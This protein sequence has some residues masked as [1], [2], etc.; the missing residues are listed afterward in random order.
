M[1][2][3]CFCLSLAKSCWEV[4]VGMPVH[5]SLS[6]HTANLQPTR[7]SRKLPSPACAM[8]HAQARP[9]TWYHFQLI[10]ALTLGYVRTAG[11]ALVFLRKTAVVLKLLFPQLQSEQ[12]QPSGAVVQPHPSLLRETMVLIYSPT[13]ASSMGGWD[14][15]AKFASSHPTAK[16]MA[17][18][19]H[20][21]ALWTSQCEQRR[22]PLS[23]A[24]HP[25]CSFKLIESCQCAGLLQNWRPSCFQA[26]SGDQRMKEALK[27]FRNFPGAKSTS[28]PF[29]GT[30]HPAA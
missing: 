18:G 2:V 12:A 1:W 29:C 15:R 16:N 13:A 3:N 6:D 10:N 5:L 30:S 21:Q 19:T 26:Y 9:A 4:E 14:R 7:S 17:P 11:S 25:C 24:G 28:C 8:L 23:V 20:S 27:A 22:Q